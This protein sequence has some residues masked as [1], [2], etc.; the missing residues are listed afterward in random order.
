VEQNHISLEEAVAVA[1]HREEQAQPVKLYHN[2]LTHHS[3]D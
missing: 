3:T 2:H 1:A